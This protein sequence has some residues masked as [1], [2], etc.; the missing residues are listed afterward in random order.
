MSFKATFHIE[1]RSINILL[2]EYTFTRQLN[3]D[4]FPTTYPQSGLIN[5][6][7]EVTNENSFIEEWSLSPT[8]KKDCRI[9][10]YKR[11]NI[12]K[13][14]ELVLTDVYCTQFREKFSSL[15]VHPFFIEVMLSAGEIKYGLSIY[16]NPW[17]ENTGKDKDSKGSTSE[18][19]FAS[20]HS[21]NSSDDEHME[22]MELK[23]VV[24]SPKENNT[25]EPD[26]VILENEEPFETIVLQ[27]VQVVPEEPGFIK[28]FWVKAVPYLDR[29]AGPYVNSIINSVAVKIANSIP[30]KLATYISDNYMGDQKA[31]DPSWDGKI[32]HCTD[33]NISGG[34]CKI[35]SKDKCTYDSAEDCGGK[36]PMNKS[37][38]ACDSKS[39]KKVVYMNGIQ[40][41]P[42]TN[43]ETSKKM[44]KE[45]CIEVVSMYNRT[46]GI[47]GDLSECLRNIRKA[48]KVPPSDAMVK[49]LENHFGKPP[50]EPYEE[51]N[52]MAH[53][54]GGL[55]TQQS[56]IRFK[57]NLIQQ[58]IGEEKVNKI[59]GNLKVKSFGTAVHGW[60][61][62]PQYEQFTN[63]YDPVPQVIS[64]AQ[65]K[66]K[67]ETFTPDSEPVENIKSH[68]IVDSKINPIGPHSM[69]NVYLKK[70]KETTS[71]DIE[72]KCNSCL[73]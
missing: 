22:E 52:L 10:F 24:V 31:V 69:D 28:K 66:Y 53:S 49:M 33:C 15:G 1:E 19:G 60:P 2:C 44:A 65:L 14:K 3:K 63:Y 41:D 47:G 4:Y 7:F 25:I 45:L 16:R 46:E 67:D 27:E 51:L 11:D 40:T 12:S 61:K 70:L 42:K 50:K 48:K 36:K 26:E 56:L 13:M 5:L 8:Q 57:D 6:L 62:G 35:S 68:M 59:I 21:R 30:V 55:V 71:K 23:E 72:G 18:I 58:E 34:S 54:Q 29:H 73:N 20:N 17:F 39:L 32:L 43:C 37:G 64:C 9:I 38:K